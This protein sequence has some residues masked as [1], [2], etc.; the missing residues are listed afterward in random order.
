[1]LPPRYPES[2]ENRLNKKLVKVISKGKF[3]K[4]CLKVKQAFKNDRKPHRN[5]DAAFQGIF[6]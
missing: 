1:L 3:L 6:G 5:I 2:N 4:T